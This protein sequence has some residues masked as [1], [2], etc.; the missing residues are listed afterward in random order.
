MDGISCEIE[1]IHNKAMNTKKAA[2]QKKIVK[3]L[4]HKPVVETP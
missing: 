4:Q 3:A 1:V 2:I